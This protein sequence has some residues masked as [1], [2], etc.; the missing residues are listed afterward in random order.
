MAAICAAGA[1]PSISRYNCSMIAERQSLLKMRPRLGAGLKWAGRGVLDLVLP[2]RCLSC[3][4]PV[5][6]P[7]VVCLPCWQ[8]LDFIERPFCQ[9]LG[10]PF[11]AD[12][13]FDL[14]SPK[15]IADPPIFG[16]ARAVARYEGTARLMVHRLKYADRLDLSATMGRWMARAGAEILH[17]AD[18]LVPVPLHRMRLWGRRF[19]QAGELAK[20]IG[21]ESGVRVLHGNLVRQKATRSQVGLSSRERASNVAGAFSLR[22]SRAVADKRIILVDDVMTT[23]STLNSAA[24]ALKKAGAAEVDVLVFALVAERV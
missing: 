14:I 10:T 11:A 7:G 22:D 8:E 15:A 23:G 20:A 18:A 12:L 1:R 21:Q 2:P 16:R 4:S 19:N 17:D 9:R 6:E 5:S 3:A 13:G 24:R